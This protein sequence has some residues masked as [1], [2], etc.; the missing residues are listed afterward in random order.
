MSDPTP[1][2]PRASAGLALGVLAMALFGATLPVTRLATGTDAAPLLSP[3]FVT[4]GRL[5]VAAVPSA[6]VLLLTRSTWPDRRLAKALVVAALGNAIVYPLSLALAL[7][8]VSAP[9]V[10]VVTAGLPLATAICAALALGQ[11]QRRAFWG[12]AGATAVVLVVHAAVRSGGAGRAWVPAWPDLLVMLGV[13]GASI[14]YVQGAAAT[15]SLGAE[16][17]I[18]WVVLATLPVSLPVAIATW[19]EAPVPV[20]AWASF[21]YVSLVSMWAAFF[22]WYRALDWGGP[23]RVSQVQALQPFFAIAL[24]VPLLGDVVD[25]WTMA[26]AVAVIACVGLAQ[27]SA[28]TRR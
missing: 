3:W 28:G 4:F 9:H 22:A 8:S 23:V 18:C 2:H 24:S 25:A 1:P 27:R 15:R 11:A 19:P 13:V 21:G 10:A 26:C 5:V 6:L 17:T 14:G 12:W 7:R 16:R 20:T